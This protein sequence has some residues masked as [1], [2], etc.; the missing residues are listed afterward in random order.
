M[1]INKLIWYGALAVLSAN[2]SAF[3]SNLAIQFPSLRIVYVL[4]VLAIGW[5]FQSQ[6]SDGFR[7][8]IAESLNLD[9][10]EFIIILFCLLIGGLIG[11]VG[12]WINQVL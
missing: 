12:T 5:F 3:I 2:I 11:G 7:Q 10:G 6:Y 8:A 4:L 9:E 1:S